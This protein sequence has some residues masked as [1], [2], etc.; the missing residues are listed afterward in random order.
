MPNPIDE[1]LLATYLRT[2]EIGWNVVHFNEVES[3]NI[4][5]LEMARSGASE[6]T[7]IVAENQRAGRGRLGRVWSSEAGKNL[8]FSVV[9]RPRTSPSRIGIIPLLAGI[10]VASALDEFSSESP[11]CKWPN[12][13][14]LGGGKI[15]GILCES[16]IQDGAIDA[17]VVGVGINVNQVDF[18]EDIATRP[19]SL[20]AFAGREFD[21]TRV[22]ASVLNRLGEFYRLFR[23]GQDGIIIE[24]WK[25]AS[26]MIGTEV[27]INRNGTI[28]RGT[29]LDV[30]KDGSLI[31]SVEGKPVSVYA[32]DVT[33]HTEGPYVARN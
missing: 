25:N 24:A 13:V 15:S 11:H 3:T 27:G 16:A 23:T 7:A 19:A 17:V 22:L 29:A 14:L 32:G 6:G 20:A 26:P 30:G 10:S 4:T 33:L 12:D 9:L 1:R 21:R 8:T 18:P 28:L 2:H 31:L 5:A